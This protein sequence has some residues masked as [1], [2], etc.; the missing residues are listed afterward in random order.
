MA[1][2]FIFN[3]L[4]VYQLWQWKL[5]YGCSFGKKQASEKSKKGVRECERV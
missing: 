1:G 5:F 4:A 3:Y 2:R